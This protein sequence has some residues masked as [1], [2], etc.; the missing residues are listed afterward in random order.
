M[1]EINTKRLQQLYIAFFGRPG[2]PSGIKYWLKSKEKDLDISDISRSLFLQNEYKTFINFNRNNEFQINQLYM[3]LFGRKVDFDK[4][5]SWLSLLEKGTIQI[6]DIVCELITIDIEYQK[7][8][9]QINR[10]YQ[11]MKN[12]VKFAE[13][14]TDEVSSNILFTNLYKPKSIDPW[15]GGE[16]INGAINY[17]NKINSDSKVSIDSIRKFI[18][19]IS[20]GP[21]QIKYQPIIEIRNLSLVIPVLCSSDKK[22]TRLI[23]NRMRKSVIGG[24]LKRL[25]TGTEV[26]VLKDINLTVMKG[27]R[28]ALIGHNGSGKSSFLKIIAG[29]YSPTQGTLNVYNSV[30]PMLQKNF[31]TSVDLSGVEACKAHYLLI[32]SNLIGFEKF[33]ED[34]INFSGLGEYISFPIK[35]YSEGMCARL[36]FSILTS[37]PHECLA[38][39]EGFGTG[40]SDFF[41]KADQR[42]KEFINSAGT[43]FLASHSE[44]LLR[45]FCTR[46]LVFNHGKIV[47]DGFLDSALNYYHSSDYYEI[48]AN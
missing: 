34:I 36:I 42:M 45:Q 4:L 7:N 22:L 38:I 37:I 43:L 5:N 40:D 30:Y 20:S 47:Y 33:L 23:T 8:S 44:T 41:E 15:V 31:L 21:N 26:E 27:E 3:N 11:T 29:I 12:K 13:I 28:V 1:V 18:I 25:N 16:F 46:G 2:D 9:E 39:D 32:N 10:D 6:P 17:L 48:N 35:T 19:D 24:E 14:F